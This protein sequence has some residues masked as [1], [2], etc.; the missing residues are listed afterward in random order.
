MGTSRGTRA[1]LL[2]LV[3]ASLLAVPT[4]AGAGGP[5]LDWS[6][7]AYIPGEI[8]F[9][10]TNV[11]LKTTFEDRGR[12]RLEAGPYYAYLSP[13]PAT[14]RADGGLRNWQQ[15]SDDWIP[16]G[17]VHIEPRPDGR[18]GTATVRFRLPELE[19][20]IY[21]VDACNQSCAMGLGDLVGTLL[22]VVADES[23]R[24]LMIFTHR[25]ARDLDRLQVRMKSEVLGDKKRSLRSSIDA[26]AERVERLEDLSAR[27]SVVPVDVTDDGAPFTIPLLVGAAAI[28]AAIAGRRT[29]RHLRTRPNLRAGRQV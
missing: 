6:K 12:G 19:P 16:V 1:S 4:P 7:Q 27:S 8:V 5:Q 28:A 14:R 17:R 23:E 13:Q 3:A 25:I 2:V 11:W 20:G 24:R 26:L 18:Y 21:W 10:R 9:G 22:N 15:V 29:A